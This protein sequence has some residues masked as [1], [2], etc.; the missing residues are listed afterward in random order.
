MCVVMSF[1][2]IPTL[3]NFVEEV[4]KAGEGICDHFII[5]GLA[6][7]VFSTAQFSC[8]WEQLL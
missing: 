7:P 6:S 4:M 8:F 5:A 3:L 1:A 2:A